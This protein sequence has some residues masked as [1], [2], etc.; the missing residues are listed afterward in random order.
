MG[1]AVGEKYMEQVRIRSARNGV[2]FTGS[3]RMVVRGTKT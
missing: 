2:Q 1:S 3:A